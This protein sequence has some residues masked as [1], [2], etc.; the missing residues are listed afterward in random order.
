MPTGL[1]LLALAPL[2]LGAAPS[3]LGQGGPAPWR[4][5][6][7]PAE[8]GWSP[9]RLEE[10]RRR[11]AGQG[12]AALLVV[13]GG[14]VVAAW[15]AI[16]VPFKLASMRKSVYSL[17]CGVFHGR[18]SFRLDATLA[19]LGIDDLRALSESE[20]GARVHDLMAARSGVYHP[21]AYET[22]SNAAA[23]P[24]RGSA[25]PGSAWYYNNWDFNC[26]PVAFERMCG[27][28]LVRALED[29]LLVPLGCQDFVAARD[30]FEFLEPSLSRHPAQL[31]RMSARDVARLGELVRL[32]G[33]SGERQ[34][35]PADWIELA[36]SPIT[37]FGPGHERG[38]GNGYGFMW[39]ILP[40]R[41]GADSV[42]DRHAR[43][44]AKGAGGQLLALVPDLE[45]TLVHFAD[46]DATRG[47]SDPQVVGLLG[48]LLEAREAEPVAAPTLVPLAP[49]PLGAPPR[50]RRTHADVPAAEIAAV[51]GRWGDGDGGRIE[52]F[53]HAGRLFARRHE[54][55]VLEAEL[56]LGSDGHLFAPEAPV[57]VEVLA[58]EGGRA[59]SIAVTYLGRRSLG[60]RE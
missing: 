11:A 3:V 31:L 7:D 12:S 21:A 18:G 56:R 30:A 58:R 27:V 2:S 22:E 52:L 44:L 47:L 46:T 19:E 43:I 40:A 60:K 23:R 8:A 13:Q 25:S 28:P 1:L 37:T 34:L 53:E 9:E 24:E 51:A 15:G 36:T 54:K 20:K 59:T 33:T 55:R 4:Q 26:V 39:W 10:L 16:D 41:S 42:W 49:Q 35:V 38:E 50:P 57:D 5:Y 48:S 17:V 29:E 32:G 45:L 14:H 6:A